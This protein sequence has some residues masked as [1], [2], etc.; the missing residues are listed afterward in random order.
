ME[1][2]FWK[3][4]DGSPGAHVSTQGA[5]WRQNKQT[6]KWIINQG[7]PTSFGY[8]QIRIHPNTYRVHRLVG[9]A[10][11]SNPSSLPQI[12]HINTVKNDNRASNLEWCDCL[13]NVTHAISMGLR[14]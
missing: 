1:L 8:R 11:V 6:G 2:E 10:F 7:S 14:R 4:I 5:V 9:F 3:E 12:N 13:Y